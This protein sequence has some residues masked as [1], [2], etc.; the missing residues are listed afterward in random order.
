MKKRIL[1]LA[2]A[3]ILCVGLLPSAL[4]MPSA[5]DY[6]N[7]S[8]GMI[9]NVHIPQKSNPCWGTIRTRPRTTASTCM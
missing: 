5:E 1:A 4:A 2:M 7:G 3:L 8:A 9:P 6:G